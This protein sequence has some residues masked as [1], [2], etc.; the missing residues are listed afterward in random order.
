[1]CNQTTTP[2]KMLNLI[3]G[4][5]YLMTDAWGKNRAYKVVRK[6]KHAEYVHSYFCLVPSDDKLNAG[7][8]VWDHGYVETPQGPKKSTQASYEVYS[9]QQVSQSVAELYWGRPLKE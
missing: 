7:C 4:K 9:G 6:I 3:P 8:Y 5:F 1:M 2:T